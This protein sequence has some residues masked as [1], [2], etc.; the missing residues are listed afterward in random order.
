VITKEN[1]YAAFLALPKDERRIKKLYSKLVADGVDPP[2]LQTLCD[3]SAQNKW[4]ARASEADGAVQIKVAEISETIEQEAKTRITLAT[5]AEDAA[6]EGFACVERELANIKIRNVKDAKLMAELTVSLAE[7]A[8]VMKERGL[9]GARPLL[10][11]PYAALAGNGDD[12]IAKA[13][14]GLFLPPPDGA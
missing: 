10:E 2:A 13:L 14:E 1:C 9:A 4:R 11:G 3:W 12:P 7:A 6:Y 8:T 5:A